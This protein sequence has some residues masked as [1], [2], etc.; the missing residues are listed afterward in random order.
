MWPMLRSPRN[1]AR[2]RIAL[3]GMVAS[4][5]CR[6]VARRRT[7][8]PGA[9]FGAAP[10]ARARARRASSSAR[11]RTCR[12]PSPRRSPLQRRP[13][14]RRSVG[15]VRQ[16]L[17]ER[18]EQ[19]AVERTGRAADL[20]DQRRPDAFSASGSGFGGDA[21]TSASTASKP[22]FMLSAMIAVADRLIELGQLV[23]AGND[24][25]ATASIRACASRDRSSCVPP[26][27][28]ARSR[29]PARIEVQRLDQLERDPVAR[30][31]LAVRVA[32][33]SPA[34]ASPIVEVNVVLIAEMLDPVHLADRRPAIR[35]ARFADARCATPTVRASGRRGRRR[36]QIGG[37]EVD[38]RARPAGVAT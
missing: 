13:R 22:R 24:R 29:L 36:Q 23:G 34:H 2:P 1:D 3:I 30:L 8:K 14:P 6:A 15:S 16:C 27:V 20:H 11:H 31:E 7:G 33:A 12:A 37:K 19:R 18:H 35:L 28:A 4:A 25:C 26:P 17:A 9:A 32:Q 38:R 5:A 10:P 21:S